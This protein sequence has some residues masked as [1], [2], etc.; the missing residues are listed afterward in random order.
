MDNIVLNFPERNQSNITFEKSKE[1]WSGECT[2]TKE[3]KNIT[4]EFK[5]CKFSFDIKA[6]AAI[7]EVGLQIGE[8]Y[9]IPPINDND[10]ATTLANTLSV[11]VVASDIKL[12]YPENFTVPEPDT[13]IY[14]VKKFFGMGTHHPTNEEIKKYKSDLGK[15]IRNGIK[16][17][18][19]CMKDV[20]LEHLPIQP[21]DNV[22]NKDFVFENKATEEI[23]ND[24]KIDTK[25]TQYSKYHF[26]LLHD[27][28]PQCLDNVVTGGQYESCKDEK[29]IKLYGRFGDIK[30]HGTTYPECYFQN[31]M[32]TELLEHRDICNTKYFYNR[33]AASVNDIK[34]ITFSGIANGSDII[35]GDGDFNI[36]PLY[37]TRHIE[38]L[39]PIYNLLFRLER[40]VKSIVDV[41]LSEEM[42]KLPNELV[43]KVISAGGL[44]MLRV[45]NKLIEIYQEPNTD[46][47]KKERI[48]KLLSKISK[49]MLMNPLYKSAFGVSFLGEKWLENII[50]FYKDNP[51]INKPKFRLLTSI[52]DPILSSSKNAIPMM[53]KLL[54]SDL[55]DF[56]AKIYAE[57]AHIVGAK[58]CSFKVIKK[59]GQSATYTEHEYEKFKSFKASATLNLIDIQRAKASSVDS[60]GNVEVLY[61]NNQG[62]RVVQTVKNVGSHG[63]VAINLNSDTVGAILT[64]N[65]N[66]LWLNVRDKDFP[67]IIQKAR[68]TLEPIL[69][70]NKIQ[71]VESINQV[72]NIAPSP[73]KDSFRL[74]QSQFQD[75]DLPAY[76]IA[77]EL[78]INSQYIKNLKGQFSP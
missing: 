43:V 9:T 19:E 57:K 67:G 13:L 27:K 29:K 66:K 2:C 35:N 41:L 54:A 36:S 72:E 63:N 5:G 44:T 40:K 26:E 71:K 11:W 42:E 16:F 48:K 31:G 14:K 10:V 30:I 38:A 22:Q 32:R 37:H 78:P 59:P 75:K 70:K 21:K 65:K 55:F 20:T 47:N 49:I 4:G 50:N 25:N 46:G 64:K 1:V 45:L 39:V 53:E 17:F 24:I 51:D 74:N 33:G 76:K 52:H 56:K 23:Y 28:F 7:D 62:T 18:A 58:L 73:L 8:K 61:K 69:T 77:N 12:N 34:N 60:A 3:F 68:E 15:H 6:T